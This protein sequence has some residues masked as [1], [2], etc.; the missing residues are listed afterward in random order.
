MRPFKKKKKNPNSDSKENSKTKAAG[1]GQAYNKFKDGENRQYLNEL[2]KRTRDKKVQKRLELLLSKENNLLKKIHIIEKTDNNGIEA[3]HYY[4]NRLKFIQPLK[5]KKRIH[6][7]AF[8]SPFK[9]NFNESFDVIF[10]DKPQSKGSLLIND[11]N[12][13]SLF[14]KVNNVLKS[15]ILKIRHEL[16]P[17]I[18]QFWNIELKA[19]FNFIEEPIFILVEEGWTVLTKKQYN[20]FVQLQEL[21]RYY[22]NNELIIF[23]KNLTKEFFVKIYP[24]MRLFFNIT[25]N[26]ENKE[27]LLDGMVQFFKNI[28]LFSSVFRKIVTSIEKLLEN[29]QTGI[30]LNNVLYAVYM[31]YFKR[32]LNSN[33]IYEAFHISQVDNSEFQCPKRIIE[34]ISIFKKV[35]KEELALLKRDQFIIN[36]LNFENDESLMYSFY[37]ELFHLHQSSLNKN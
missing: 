13:I 12:K 20:I 33:K 4:E 30:N 28:R 1:K 32:Y 8:E 3:L 11:W 35:K 23:S 7:Y 10:K 2:F 16:T 37:E 26:P 17:K 9:I 31:G 22:F 25:I 34:K 24:F 21:I 14:G 15:N 29:K 6:R 36:T 18:E 19:I 27:I 5:I